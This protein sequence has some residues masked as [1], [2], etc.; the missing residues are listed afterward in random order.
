MTKS[1]TLA[2]LAVAGAVLFGGCKQLPRNWNIDCTVEPKPGQATGTPE[3]AVTPA[4]TW[5]TA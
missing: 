3:P 1:R 2:A 4:A 5:A